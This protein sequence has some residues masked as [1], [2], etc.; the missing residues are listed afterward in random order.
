MKFSYVK[1]EWEDKSKR[2]MYCNQCK[3]ASENVYDAF[4]HEIWYKILHT[5][6]GK[7]KHKTVEYW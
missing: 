5:L 3:F 4:Y 6:F 1:E 7:P 2:D